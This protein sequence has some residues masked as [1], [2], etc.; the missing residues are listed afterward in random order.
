MTCSEHEQSFISCNFLGGG[1]IYRSLNSR[2]WKQLLRIKKL[3]K[4]LRKK[5]TTLL[6]ERCITIVSMRNWIAAS[7]RV[8]FMI[9][10]Y[11]CKTISVTN[12]HL[13]SNK[14]R[15]LAQVPRFF[16]PSNP[17]DHGA[18]GVGNISSELCLFKG[19]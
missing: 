16:Y 10:T 14:N 11:H 2:L 6:D 4:E 8:A 3:D 7:T 17:E 19:R 5:G 9:Y 12:V 13:R 15:L 1:G 18:I